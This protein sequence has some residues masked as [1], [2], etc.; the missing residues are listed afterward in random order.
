[1]TIFPSH[2]FIPEHHKG[3]RY[4]GTDRIYARQMW[5]TTLRAYP[6][7]RG[8]SPL[9]PEE[10]EAARQDILARLQANLDRVAP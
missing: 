9:T 10:V 5:A 6:H 4:T 7:S 8:R 1:V 2:Y 3:D